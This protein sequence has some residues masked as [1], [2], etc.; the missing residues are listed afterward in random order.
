MQKVNPL[1]VFLQI[2]FDKKEV[3]TT[4]QARHR[5]PK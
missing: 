2:D 1:W 5:R 3:Y 4:K